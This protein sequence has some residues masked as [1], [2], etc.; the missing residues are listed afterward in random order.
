MGGTVSS[1][2]IGSGV[3]TSDVID[4]LKE[5]DKAATVTPIEREI[6]LNDQKKQAMD[7]LDSLMSSF[8][9]STS[10]L[11]DDTIFQNRTVNGTTDAITVTANPGVDTQSFSITDTSLATSSVNQSGSFTSEDSLV[12][13][14]DGS[15]NLNID[16]QDFTIDYTASTTLTELKDQ[17]NEVAGESVTA[18]ILQTGDNEFSLV[19]KSDKTGTA[20]DITLT[21]NSGNIDDKL[22][23][24]TFKSD[25]FTDPSDAV[26]SSD[27][28]MTV[29]VG[30]VSSTI[31]YTAD[32]SLQDL[33]DAINNDE[34]LKDVAVANIVQESDGNYT[35]VINPIGS[36]DGSDVSIVD[37]DSGLDTKLTDTATNTTGTMDEVQ[38]A[39]DAS[40]KYNGIE[41]TRASN[42]IDDLIIGVDIQLNSNDSSANISIEQDTQ[43][44]KD[45]L[46]NFVD[47]Y[48]SLIS[49]LDDMTQAD[50]EKG[51]QGI[52]FADSSIRN[53]G[54]DLTRLITSSDTN[55]NSLANFGLELDQKGTLSFDPV[56]FQDTFDKDPE[57]AQTYF[58]GEL[59]EEK[60]TGIFDKLNDKVK[61]Y[62]DSTNGVLSILNQ[63][64]EKERDNLDTSY[65]R[66]LD[67]LNSRYDTMTDRF[68][69]YD[70]MISRMNAQFSSLQ[71]MI[72]QS[73]NAKN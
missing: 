37:N 64:L 68:T 31:D 4:Q 8:K 67:L 55:G 19:L 11:A 54:R 2:G 53:M 70:A 48:N 30:G 56:A 43:P 47:A 41:I 10:S 27:G 50:P 3:L 51:T 42:T 38:Q 39:Q 24:K 15:L 72:D 63:G 21:D 28:S 57:A 17:I 18:S 12:A 1:L 52:F 32:M 35:L 73:V 61:S 9:G 45:E 66:A 20:Q 46:Q 6:T 33:Q 62:T 16:G 29:S 49:Q 34:A 69:E 44:I 26:A 22:I 65:Q 58:S 7:L 36:E 40:F 14:G 60:G 13:S 25:Y 71:M 23:N 59:G 5:A